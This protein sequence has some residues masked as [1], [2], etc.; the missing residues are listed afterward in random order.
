MKQLT[1]LMTKIDGKTTVQNDV[2]SLNDLD[3]WEKFEHDLSQLAADAQNLAKEAEEIYKDMMSG[4]MFVPRSH[5][6]NQ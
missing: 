5:R 1:H 2:R 4:E 6:D 3:K